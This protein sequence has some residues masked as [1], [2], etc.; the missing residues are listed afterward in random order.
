[1]IKTNELFRVNITPLK[2]INTSKYIVRGKSSGV[3]YGE[4][5]TRTGQEV[6]LRNARRLWYWEGAA[7]L[8]QLAK[9]GTV[10]PEECKFTIKVDEMLILDAIE[11]IRCSEAAV[12]SID[13]VQEWKMTR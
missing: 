11:I 2:E 6:T 13:E 12:K 3:F 4:I 1:M 10:V 7:S 9:E 5:L 8:S